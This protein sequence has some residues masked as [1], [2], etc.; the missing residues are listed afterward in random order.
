M[1]SVTFPVALGGDG[2]TYTDDAHPDTGL[3]G[4]GYI[5]RLVP[6]FKNGLAMAGYTA[7]YAAKIDAAAANADRAEDAKRYVEAVADAYAVNL[8]DAYRDKITLGADFS[9]GRYVRDDGNTRLVTDDPSEIFTIERLGP[10]LALGMQGQ[11]HEVDANALARQWLNGECEGVNLT[12][13]ATGVLRNSSDCLATNWAGTSF[14]GVSATSIFAQGSAQRLTGDNYSSGNRRQILSSLSSGTYT[15]AAI[16]ENAIDN[17]AES[18]RIALYNQTDG[19][20]I[21]RVALNWQTAT[22]SRTDGAGACGFIDLGNIG[23][24][25]GRVG[26]IWLT[27][28]DVPS[29]KAIGCYLYPT[30][31]SPNL[32]SVIHHQTQ[33]A[34]GYSIPFDIVTLDTPITRPADNFSKSDAQLNPRHGTFFL[35]YKKPLVQGVVSQILGLGTGN[36]EELVV[37][38]SVFGST[39]IGF[40]TQGVSNIVTDG[41]FQSRPGDLERA[42][43]TYQQVSSG[44]LVRFYVNGTIV[45]EFNMPQLPDGFIENIAVGKRRANSNTRYANTV[46]ES[47]DYIPYA[48]GQSEMQELTA[49]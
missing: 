11:I 17:P 2:K 36:D 41:V 7:Q 39:Y 9:A 40:G 48:L 21:S 10:K 31:L 46:I 19:D 16:F 15:L 8:L 14:S 47:V 6:L 33:L 5:T 22:V 38:N 45:N 23:P 49:L 43:F 28:D 29:G 12:S 42:G 20:F 27:V 18:T 25:G 1:A 34:A 37:G 32:Q 24:N 3:D 26:V 13:S 4:L 30:G 35:A 44:V